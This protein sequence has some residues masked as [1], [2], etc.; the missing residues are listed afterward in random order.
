MQAVLLAPMETTDC[1][2][3]D[4]YALQAASSALSRPIFILLM[5][6]L[7]KHV[8]TSSIVCAP[9]TESRL[10]A[11]LFTILEWNHSNTYAIGSG[12]LDRTGVPIAWDQMG[13]LAHLAELHMTGYASATLPEAWGQNG[14][15]PRLQ[16]L[17]L[18]LNNISGTL[19]AA[20][21]RDGGFSQLQQLDLSGNKI[22]GTLPPA[23]GSL[24]RLQKLN[25]SNNRVG[26][27]LPAAWGQ[28]ESFAQLTLLDLSSNN[29]SGTVPASWGQPGSFP[30]VRNLTLSNNTIDGTTIPAV[31]G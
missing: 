20:W 1:V 16:T 4:C 2:T 11:K 28:N 26:G 30:N 29:I 13:C 22:S 25:L 5:A 21:G 27:S 15:F 24:P 10:L 18:R 7:A 17:S 12:V 8:S 31:W 6:A 23:W 3:P 9:D 19:P 14:S